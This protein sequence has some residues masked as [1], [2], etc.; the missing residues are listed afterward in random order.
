M[1]SSVS[2]KDEIWFLRVCQ[3]ISNPVS[4]VPEVIC[5]LTALVLK[6][7]VLW[8]VVYYKIADKSKEPTA[9]VFLGGN[10]FLRNLSK[11][12]PGRTAAHPI[13]SV[14]SVASTNLGN[15]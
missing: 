13:R 6:N 5:E 12:I 10:W 2:P 3:H 8:N 14:I 4:N 11:F 9:F 1:D 7:S 15:V